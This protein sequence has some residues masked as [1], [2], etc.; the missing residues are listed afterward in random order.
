MCQNKIIQICDLIAHLHSL[1]HIEIGFTETLVC[2]R[3]H[4][5]DDAVTHF[6]SFDSLILV[7]D[8]FIGTRT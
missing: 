3:V 4:I 2:G 7:P 6:L 5:Y 8:L 1:S